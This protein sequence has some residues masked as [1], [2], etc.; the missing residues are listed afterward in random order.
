MALR[1]SVCIDMLFREVPFLDRLDRVVATGARA[2]E[3]WRW[4]EKD[5][6]A[7]AAR[8]RD[9]GLSCAAIMA[10][11]GESL[12][13]ATLRATFL[14]SLRGGVAAAHELGAPTLIVTVGTTV[15]GVS[16]QDQRASI[17]AALLA[18]APIAADAGL[19][20]A[21]EPLNSRVNHP[22]YVLDSVVD[23]FAIL[24]E[25][26]HPAV[27]LL[28]DIY[29]AV[30]MDESDPRLLIDNVGRVAHVHVADA[31]GRHEPGTGTIPYGAIL[32]QLAA[33][34]YA[35]AVGLE[36]LPATEPVAAVSQAVRLVEDA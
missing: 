15:E 5:I 18:A 36:F 11:R 21:L 2:Y 4:H 14:E 27:K 23:G 8:A 29:H 35:G 1:C 3:F 31:P 10:G 26:G 7:V 20:L 28:Y 17:V 9:L 16:R 6:P 34:D 32:G 30:V 19:T 12:V 25:V 22:G 13:D 24:D 33:T